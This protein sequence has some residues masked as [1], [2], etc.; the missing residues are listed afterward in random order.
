MSIYRDFLGSVYYPLRL[1]NKLFNLYNKTPRYR[2]RILSYHD[3]PET[4]EPLFI[5]QLNWL[6]KSWEIISPN[7]FELIIDGKEVLKRDSLLLTFDDGTMSNFNVARNILDPLNIKALFF[8]VTNYAIIGDNENW[9]QFINEDIMLNKYD[10]EIPKY[11][12]NMSIENLKTLKKNGHSIG[13]H[14]LNHA[15]LS[16]LN[17]KK[18][19]DE[20]V[21]GADKLEEYIDEQINHFAYPFGN[22]ESIN[23]KASLIACKR[24]KYVY[25]GI[26]GDNGLTN[27]GS[28]IWR[29]SNEPHDSLWYTS[30][31]LEGGADFLYRKKRRDCEEWGKKRF[32]LKKK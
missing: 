7:K 26:R 30:A 29:D 16:N 18:L 11:L 12:K 20:I 1:K 25:T 10:K 5:R 23:S 4:K 17:G 9:K 14:T 6:Q 2:L 3:M 24:F 8:I 15:R 19:L 27:K 28:N 32:F 13:S 22:F 21:D 31:C